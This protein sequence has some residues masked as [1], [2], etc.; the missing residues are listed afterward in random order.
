MVKQAYNEV[1]SMLGFGF[2]GLVM[3]TRQAVLDALE[4]FKGG[5]ATSEISFE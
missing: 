5:A 3:D 1:G 4:Q 2:P